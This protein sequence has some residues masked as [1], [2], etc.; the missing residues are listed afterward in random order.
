MYLRYRKSSELISSNFHY[1]QT[2]LDVSRNHLP[3][4]LMRGKHTTMPGHITYPGIAVAHSG[5]E[6]LFQE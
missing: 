4:S 2:I 1:A 5:I 3:A 6:P